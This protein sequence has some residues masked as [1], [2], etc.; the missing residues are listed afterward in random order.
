MKKISLPIDAG[1]YDVRVTWAGLKEDF[2]PA[3]AGVIEGFPIDPPDDRAGWLLVN[4]GVQSTKDADRYWSL[5]A[6]EKVRATKKRAKRVKAL[7]A[8][9]VTKPRTPRKKRTTTETVET[10]AKDETTPETN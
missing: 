1:R 10:E 4:F 3:D 8:D 6:R 7:A 2:V 5:W 9:P